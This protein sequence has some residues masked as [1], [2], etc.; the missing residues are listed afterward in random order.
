[1]KSSVHVE[2]IVIVLFA[3]EYCVGIQE[4]LG[5]GLEAGDITVM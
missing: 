1:M 4:Q 5:L 2:K 3:R